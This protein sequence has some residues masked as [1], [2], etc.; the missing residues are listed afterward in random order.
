MNSWLREVWSLPVLSQEFRQGP[1]VELSGGA[2]LLRY[3][4][5]TEAGEY[6]WQSM[7]FD[8]VEAFAFTSHSSCTEDMIEAY[9]AL[10]EVIGSPWVARLQAGRGEPAIGLRHLRIYFD[11]V[12]C[13]EV[14]ARGF[15][16]P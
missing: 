13:Y 14:V 1:V 15:T 7:A 5:E 8:G 4:C 2:I 3:D 11:E 9:D 10:V 12:G 6:A 16:A